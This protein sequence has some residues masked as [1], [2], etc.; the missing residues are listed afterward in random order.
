MGKDQQRSSYTHAE[1]TVHAPPHE[2]TLRLRDSPQLVVLTH[3][4]QLFETMPKA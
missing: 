1:Q 3:G 2:V 4:T